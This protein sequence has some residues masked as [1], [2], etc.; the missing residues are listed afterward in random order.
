MAKSKD[1]IRFKEKGRKI[2]IMSGVTE[3]QAREWCE[4]PLTR[5]KD[6]FDGFADHG[7]HCP[8]SAPKYTH[9]FAPTKEYH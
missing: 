7:T 2:L 1:I 9:Y 4:S 5:G 3:D 8:K 6:W